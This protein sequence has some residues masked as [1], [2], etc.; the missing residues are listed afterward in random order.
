MER[1]ERPVE[2]GAAVDDTGLV[3][4]DDRI[5]YVLYGGQPVIKEQESNKQPLG[6]LQGWGDA[7]PGY[8][9]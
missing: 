6:P 2:V 1:I 8:L 3:V 4:R 9:R 5:V 7:L